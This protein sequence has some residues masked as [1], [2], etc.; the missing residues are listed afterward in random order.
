MYSLFN[1][2]GKL[3]ILMELM[4]S[5]SLLEFVKD[6]KLRDATLRQEFLNKYP[7]FFEI[8]L[9]QIAC[10]MAY[11]ESK[12][13]MH[14]DLAARNCLLKFSGN[15]FNV[16]ISDFGLARHVMGNEYN[17]HKETLLPTAHSAPE[18]LKYETIPLEF[19]SRGDVWSF[20]VVMWEIYTFGSYPYGEDIG[21]F[22]AKLLPLLLDE[23]KRLE[24]PENTPPLIKNLALQ[25]CFQID[26]QLRPTFDFICQKLN[27]LVVNLDY[28]HYDRV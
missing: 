3:C 4:T 1:E 23:G 25:H 7:Q 11:L 6:L 20:G 13:I 19:I 17:P 12:K 14:R 8:C 24:F 26:P 18:V 28:H 10:G 22:R 2:S 27:E 16:K 21:R 9:Q 15:I 5:G